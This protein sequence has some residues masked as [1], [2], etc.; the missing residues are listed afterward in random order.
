LHDVEPHG[1]EGR[2]QIG[3][4]SVVAIVHHIHREALR[5]ERLTDEHSGFPLVLDN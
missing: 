5:L 3:G 4:E 2:R 1:I